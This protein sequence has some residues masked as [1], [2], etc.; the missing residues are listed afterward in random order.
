MEAAKPREFRNINTVVNAVN[1]NITMGMDGRGRGGGFGGRGRGGGRF[2]GGRGGYQVR[3]GHRSR[4]PNERRGGKGSHSF[5]L[6]P[7]LYCP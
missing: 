3:G 1:A 5:M 7:L 2:D 4:G 6:P